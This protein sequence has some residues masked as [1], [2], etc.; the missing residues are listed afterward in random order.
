MMGMHPT[1]DFAAIATFDDFA[2][3]EFVIDPARYR[4]LPG[5]T[6]DLGKA[7]RARAD[8]INRLASLTR[9]SWEADTRLE[10]ILE[11]QR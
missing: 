7:T 9:T 8:L 6:T 5:T 4:S 2:V 10:A 3:N 11:E 1:V